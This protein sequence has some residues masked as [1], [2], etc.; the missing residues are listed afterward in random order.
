VHCICG[1]IHSVNWHVN[2]K[3]VS[4][5][6]VTNTLMLRT[7]FWLQ[8]ISKWHVCSGWYASDLTQS[9]LTFDHLSHCSTKAYIMAEKKFK[10][11]VSLGRRC[12]LASHRCLPQNYLPAK[13][14]YRNSVIMLCRTYFGECQSKESSL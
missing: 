4:E 2:C 10:Y 9:P 1:D 12:Q 8:C 14:L 11:Q 5:N 7:V 13:M 6:K 3:W